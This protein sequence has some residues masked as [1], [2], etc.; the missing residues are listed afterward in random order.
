MRHAQKAA[1]IS[2]ADAIPKDWPAGWQFPAWAAWPPGYPMA[3]NG[4][5]KLIGEL[6]GEDFNVT[7][8]DE[9]DEITDELD[10]HFLM[11]MP[12][13]AGFPIRIRRKEPHIEDVWSKLALFQIKGFGISE[14]VEL[15]KHPA[16]LRVSVY[17]FLNLKTVINETESSPY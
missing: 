10:G 9:F 12:E 15:E 4:K 13:Y 17:S 3:Y 14:K 7:T 1:L 6:N 5:V 2:P 8:V 16:H 11:V